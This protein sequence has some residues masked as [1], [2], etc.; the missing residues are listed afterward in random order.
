MGSSDTAG[1]HSLLFAANPMPMWVFDMETLQFLEINEAAVTTY[2]FSRDEFLGM[3]IAD[4]RPPEDVPALS[5]YL[6]VPKATELLRP[7][8]WRHRRKDGTLLTVEI[9]AQDI[10]FKERKAAGGRRPS[11]GERSLRPQRDSSS[12]SVSRPSRRRVRKD[13]GDEYTW[14]TRCERFTRVTRDQA[15]Q[16]GLATSFRDVVRIAFG[17]GDSA[18]SM[19]SRNRDRKS[20]ATVPRSTKEKQFAILSKEA[21]VAPK[22]MVR[23]RGSHHRRRAEGE[24]ARLSRVVEQVTE[25]IMITDAQG[26]VTYVNPAFESISGYSR[27]EV[28]GQNPRILKSGHQDAAFYRRMWETL[29][30]GEVWKGRLVNRRKDGTLFQEDATIGPVRDAPAGRQLCGRETRCDHRDA[31]RAAARRPTRWRRSGAA[32]EGHDF[33][34]Y[35]RHR[36]IRGDR[37]RKCGRDPLTAKATDSQGRGARGGLPAAR[38]FSDR[39]FLNQVS[40]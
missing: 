10:V 19:R 5:A 15:R 6:K 14:S 20:C 13:R 12:S 29:A 33:T 17:R 32:G 21:G 28:I 37:R 23:P 25:S 38:A 8:F 7:G 30:R 1:E 39:Q 36:G 22:G 24:Q 26:T 3:T 31:A 16:D 35:R 9:T 4:I 2:G 40:T 34:T 18:T 11:A 27:A